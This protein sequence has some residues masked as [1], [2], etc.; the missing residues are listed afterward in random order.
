MRQAQR[1]WRHGGPPRR[2]GRR[3]TIESPPNSTPLRNVPSVPQDVQTARRDNRQRPYRTDKATL[4]NRRRQAPLDEEAR[5]EPNTP[6]P[7]PDPEHDITPVRPER[8]SR[9][10]ERPALGRREDR[11]APSQRRNR[12]RHRL[13]GN[14]RAQVD[15][16]SITCTAVTV[17][18]RAGRRGNPAR[19][20]RDV[21]PP[22]RRPSPNRR[23]AA[24]ENA[25]P[26]AERHADTYSPAER[27][28]TLQA[29]TPRTTSRPSERSPR[30]GGPTLTARQAGHILPSARLQPKPAR[31]EALDAGTRRAQPA[32][33]RFPSGSA[34]NPARRPTA[35]SRAPNQNTVPHRAVRVLPGHAALPAS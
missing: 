25:R 10:A 17:A 8:S 18:P 28:E 29:M 35:P 23:A 19:M 33:G 22:S 16:L 31:I 11:R 3:P 1:V 13:R 4:H 5:A 32:A 21:N 2:A 7:C 6:P 15:A 24:S 34:A 30:S 9:R 12:R 20:D 14:H 26:D 27:P